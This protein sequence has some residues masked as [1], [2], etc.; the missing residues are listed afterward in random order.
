M[1]YEMLVLDLDGTLT[2]SEKKITPPTREALIEI[3]QCGKKVVLAS[4]RPTPGVI[5][6]AKELDLKDYG[7]YILSFNGARITN[8]ATGEIIYNKILPASVIP[9]VYEIVKEYD[10]D[11]LTYSDDSIISGICPNQYTDVE[12]R[13]NSL[14]VKR[15]DNFVEYVDFPVNKLLVT[16]DP[17]ITEH[18]EKILKHK[19]HSYL[20]IY[21]SEPF[22]L[23]IMPQNIDKANSLQKLLNS[24]GLVADQM[25]CCGDGFNDLTMIEY[26]GLGVAMENAQPVVKESADFITKSNDEDGVLY[27][28]NRFM[29]D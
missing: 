15:V 21:R 18:L 4:G 14:P 28:I 8:C 23:E 27:V 26:A 29:R 17:A 11:I 1:I 24:V 7:S 25:I 10:V 16:G 5:P 12:S 6:L 20:N 22:F 13:I 9:V 2:N 3:Q 19:F